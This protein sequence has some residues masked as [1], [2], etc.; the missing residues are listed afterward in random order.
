MLVEKILMKIKDDPA[1]KWPKPLTWSSKRRDS[2]K[3]CRFHKDHGHHIDECQYLKEQIEELIQRRKL[4]KFVKKDY[5][6]HLQIEEKPTDDQREEDRDNLKPIVGEIR[7]ITGGPVVEG[8]Y[9]S[10]RK[11]VQRQVNNVHVKCLMAKHRCTGN[12]D[13]IFF[14]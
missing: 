5:Q 3:Y 6:A 8:S 4:Q 12:D 14:E 13:I 11:A 10:I 2:K 7:M 9:K 1:L